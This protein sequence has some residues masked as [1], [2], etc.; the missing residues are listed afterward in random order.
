MHGRLVILRRYMVWQTLNATLLVLAFLVVMLLG[1]RLI[2]YFGMAAEGGLQVGLLLRLI[3]YNLP[4]FLELILPVAF[5]IA[6]MLT[7]GRL[8][9][10]TEMAVLNAAGISRHKLAGLLL[11]LV[12][13][14]FVLEGYLSMVAKPW[15]VRQADNIWQEQSLAKVFDLIRPQEFMSAGNYHLYVGAVGA[16][17]EF[18]YDVM[19]IEQ[20]QDAQTLI[21]A[22]QAVQV[23]SDDNSV[24]VELHAGKRYAFNPQSQKFSVVSFDTY[25]LTI[26]TNTPITVNTKIAGQPFLT[27]W[28]TQSRAHLAEIGYRLALPFLIIF[29]LL[30]AIPFAKVHPRQGRWLKLLP[31]TLTFVLMALSIIALKD[32]ID[33]AKVGVWAYPVLLSL[34]FIALVYA[35]MHEQ[36]RLKMRAKKHGATL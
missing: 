36:L 34:I 13:V 31:A 14:L 30:L 10:D 23:A 16:Q 35:N 4:Y 20:Q 2:R 15:G 11:P 24:Q 29:A 9:A 25:R 6:L 18:V 3:G 8:Y 33:K 7:F 27:L 22:K 19:I 26:D 28:Q 1:G 17:R 5:F 12:L 21:L 32:P